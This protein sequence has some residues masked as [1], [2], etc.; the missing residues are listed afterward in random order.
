MRM[1]GAAAAGALA[2]TV[3]A[4]GAVQ[5]RA[6]GPDRAY[7]PLA[8]ESLVQDK[9]FYLLTLL[10][11]LPRAR[12]AVAGDPELA[13]AARDR[14]ARLTAASAACAEDTA[15]LVAALSWS[16]DEADQLGARLAEA[17][18]Q[19]GA[20]DELVE[21]HM[22]P[23]GRF[24]RDADLDDRALVRRAF[25]DAAKGMNHILKVWGL[26]EAPLYPKI[27]SASYPPGD[28]FWKETMGDLVRTALDDPGQ[29]EL[30]FALPLSASLDVLDFNDRD[31][32]ARM[33]PLSAGENAKAMAYARTLDWKAWKY[34]AVLV[35]G[36]SPV[37][38][39][40]P[41]S[42]IG[43]LKV[44]LGMRRWKAG[45]APLIVVSGGF[46]NPSQTRFAEAL[47][48]KRYLMRAYHVPERAILID[49][50]ARHTTTNIRN[51]ERLLFEAGAP[52]DKPIVITA[53]LQHSQYIEGQFFH[54]RCLK[55]LGY[56]PFTIRGRLSPYDLEAD[57]SLTSLHRDAADPLDP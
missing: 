19:A 22:R 13:K 28:K 44:R 1:R 51:T 24:Q 11:T 17:L 43:K 42:P 35:P 36:R 39:D 4:A 29:G 25:V 37:L 2:L 21:R 54:D 3:L 47:E 34:A 9:D 46:V 48:M 14:R 33:E 32:P 23:S 38:A 18:A 31:E 15:C 50:F 27:D 16:D 49:P 26:G 52:A 55:E 12:A 53:V 8:S 5:A 40:D 20:L 10:Q 6:V 45:L 30:F 56:V 41:L 7:V 57:L